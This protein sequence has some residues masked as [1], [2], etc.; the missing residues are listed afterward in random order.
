MRDILTFD[1]DNYEIKNC[2]IDGY[3]IT[4]RAFENIQY[5][6]KPVDDI[7]RMNIYVPECY[8]QGRKMNGYS[9]GTAPIFAHNTVGGYLPAAPGEPMKDFFGN[10]NA[11]FEALRHGYVVAAAGV[12]GRS[13]GTSLNDPMSSYTQ[14]DLEQAKG[15]MFG[16]APA[17][18]VDM[19][20][21][22]R[23]LRYNRAVIP[24][25]TERIIT[26][27]TSA[28]GALSALAGT[29]GN[30]VDYEPYLEE[31]GAADERDDIFAASCYCPIH[32]LEN[33]DAAYEW[34]FHKCH[35]YNMLSPEWKD[36]HVV[37]M[38]TVAKHFS[39]KQIKVSDDLRKLFPP[40]VNSLG[41]KDDEGLPLTLDEN[42]EGNFKEYVK[43][44]VIRSAQKELDTHQTIGQYSNL[45]I[46][47]PQDIAVENQPYLTIQ[48]KKVTDLDW[49]A[50]VEYITRF[51]PAPSFDA[52]DLTSP[53]NDE[54]GN[55]DTSARHFTDYA[56]ENSE[57]GG[58]M[59]EPEVIK[60]LN[61]IAYIGK[62][63][64]AK[65]WWIR[66]GAFDRDTAIAI[67]VILAVKLKNAGGN[68]NFELPWGLPHSGDYDLPELFEWIDQLCQ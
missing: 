39:E 64:M 52:L 26:N 20:A 24:G 58:E 38:S 53:E 60:M 40:Y 50:Y 48:D 59:A 9:L 63:D 43:L 10:R 2:E 36:G 18:I 37:R 34:M 27:G 14:E 16:K 21:A 45:L 28:G 47:V 30:S 51:K 67:P 6:R 66:H 44:Q 54:F 8:Y 55:A 25:D 42:G 35:D 46:F 5:C 13:T 1:P 17:F 3:S 32:N 12:R 22:V 41:L 31:I 65:H 23:Y 19:K 62:A 61:P 68:V 56:Y 7:Q 57:G 15:K 29:S 11:V 33:A 49:D 4:Y